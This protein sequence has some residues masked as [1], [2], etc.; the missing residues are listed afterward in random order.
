MWC[1]I[2]ARIVVV[3]PVCLGVEGARCGEPRP[4]LHFRNSGEKPRVVEQES[5]GRGGLDGGGGG[6][7]EGGSG[8]QG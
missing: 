5:G 7:G 2:E 1:V 8:G 4:G 3:F 6:G